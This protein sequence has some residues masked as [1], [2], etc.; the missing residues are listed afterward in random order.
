MPAKLMLATGPLAS[1]VPATTSLF[2]SVTTLGATLEAL[3]L[4]CLQQRDFFRVTGV[5]VVLLART[6]LVPRTSMRE[7]CILATYM[8]AHSR[9]VVLTHV[10]LSRA[11]TTGRAPAKLVVSLESDS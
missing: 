11:A 5:T 2:D 4:Q 8:T 1:H 3:V 6:T 10:K 7:A 9:V